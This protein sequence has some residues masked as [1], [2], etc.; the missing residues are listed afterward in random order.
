[1]TGDLLTTKELAQ[2]LGIGVS[3][4]KRW[5]DKSILTGIKTPGGHRRIQESELRRMANSGQFPEINWSL[6]F[7]DDCDARNL[8]SSKIVKEL[9][10]SLEQ[11]NQRQVSQ[12]L[13][14]AHYQGISVATIADEVLRPALSQIGELWYQGK[15]PIYQEHRN[16]EL[17]L[18]AVHELSGLIESPLSETA[19]VCLGTTPEGDPYHLGTLLVSMVLRQEGW[20]AHNLGPSIPLTSLTQSL[21]KYKPRMVWLSINHISDPDDF[22]KEY[23]TFYKAAKK[24]NIAVAVGGNALDPSILQDILYSFHGTRMAHLVAY[25]RSLYKPPDRPRRGRPGK[26]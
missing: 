25:V 5:M 19:P 21:K 10:D 6:L 14:S 23:Q 2:A 3:T 13:K 18:T 16:T 8:N 12:I 26:N 4:V 24:L 17:I 7:Q 9:L 15:I 1:M 11:E 22:K 20:K